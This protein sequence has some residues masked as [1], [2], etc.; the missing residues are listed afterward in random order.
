VP[1]VRERILPDAQMFA[2][3][4]LFQTPVQ[5]CLE[6]GSREVST[7]AAIPAYRRLLRLPWPQ[8]QLLPAG[9]PP[10]VMLWR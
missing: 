9:T 1:A 6:R 5:A 4:V 7:A 2:A 3:R 8:R 10:G